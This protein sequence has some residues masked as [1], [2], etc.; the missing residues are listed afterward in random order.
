MS[1]RFHQSKRM[2]RQETLTKEKCGD[3]RA[4][5]Q[6][7][8]TLA[9]PHAYQPSQYGTFD[10]D[11]G[12]STGSSG[13]SSSFGLSRKTKTKETWDELIERLFDKDESGQLMLKK[14][15]RDDSL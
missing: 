6:R 14:T 7:A 3:Y 1:W 11:C 9:V 13:E 2:E 5:L 10:E 12:S 4:A 8:V 15:Y